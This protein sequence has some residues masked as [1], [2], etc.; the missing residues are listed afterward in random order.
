MKHGYV[1]VYTGNGKGK[2]IYTDKSI[3]EGEY[4]KG[5][6]NGYGSFI[7]SKANSRTL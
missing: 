1:Q 2:T 4:V 3:Y 5:K 6:R 7:S